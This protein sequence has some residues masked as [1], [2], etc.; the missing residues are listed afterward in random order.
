MRKVSTTDTH[1]FVVCAYK[2]SEYLKTL[3]DSLFAQTIRG[4]ILISTSTPTDSIF[5]T[6]KEFD[7]EVCVSPDPK[8]IG[9]DW[10]YAYSLADTDY[11]TLAHQ[12]DV[13]EPAYTEKILTAFE[14]AKNPILAYTN[15]YEIRPEGR[16]SNNRLLRV[17][18]M[19]NA[20]IHA[21]PKSRFVRNRVLSMGCPLSCPSV[22]YNKKRFPDFAFVYDMKT[23]LDWEAWY[24]LAKEP[25]EFIYIKDLLVGHRIHQGSETSSGIDSGA[26]SAEDLEMFKRYWPDGI[27]R[28]IHRFYEKGL[29]SNVV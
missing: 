2:N 4:K 28:F 19:M 3:L 6:A 8:G 17:K 14:K 25:G 10:T 26:R 20:P 23:D 24:R 11:V 13:Y 9:S 18:S 1:T 5:E 21:F 22:A 29:K 16:V 7:L 15:Y 27:A 12:D